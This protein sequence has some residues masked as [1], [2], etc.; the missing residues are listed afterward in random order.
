MASRL[1]AWRDDAAKERRV[2][3]PFSIAF[4]GP[5]EARLATHAS[6]VLD[7]ATQAHRLATPGGIVSTTGVAGLTLGGGIGVLHYRRTFLK[8]SCAVSAQ[9]GIMR[10]TE[11]TPVMLGKA[12][13]ITIVSLTCQ[14]S[15]APRGHDRTDRQKRRLHLRVS[16]F[17]A[18]RIFVRTPWR[19]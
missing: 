9:S 16:P 6:A 3:G 15:R 5:A 11:Q 2:D 12:H 18:D 13:A 7:A 1:K 14:M 10:R 8:N 19:S 17:R 4:E